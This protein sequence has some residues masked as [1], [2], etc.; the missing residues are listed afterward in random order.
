MERTHADNFPDGQ[1][2]R[3]EKVDR[4]TRHGTPQQEKRDV[5]GG[6]LRGGVSGVRPIPKL[7]YILYLEITLMLSRTECW[8]LLRGGFKILSSLRVAPTPSHE[9]VYVR[10]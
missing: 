2:L 1:T 7:N 10:L 9:A 5:S 3:R 4:R 8:R 6:F